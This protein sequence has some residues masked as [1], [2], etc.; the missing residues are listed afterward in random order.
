MA[1]QS[2]NMPSGFGGLTRYKEEYNS[3]LK[4]SPTQVVLL[5]IL[6]IAFVLSMRIF[7]PL[8]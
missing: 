4:I 8:G 5:I 1:Q 6:V 7:W 2:I 3:K